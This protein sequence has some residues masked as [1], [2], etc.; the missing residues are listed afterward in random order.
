[1]KGVLP[2]LVPLAYHAVT[3][4]FCP[5]LAAL[6]GPVQ[7]IFPH[8]T[9]FHFICPHGPHPPA[10]GHKERQSCRVACLLILVSGNISYR[11]ICGCDAMIRRVCYEKF[12]RL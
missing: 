7:N 3:R 6:V 8:R 1:M 12:G 4:D 5:A 9:L 11:N 2:W 10:S